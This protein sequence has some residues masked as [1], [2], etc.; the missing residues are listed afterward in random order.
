MRKTK[1]L[2][3]H[4][5]CKVSVLNGVSYLEI[6]I[7]TMRQVG[8]TLFLGTAEQALDLALLAAQDAAERISWTFRQALPEA[9]EVSTQCPTEHCWSPC[10]Q[11][12]P[13]NFF[14]GSPIE[15]RAAWQVRIRWDWETPD[16]HP[17]RIA[18]RAL[19]EEMRAK[20]IISSLTNNNNTTVTFGSSWQAKT[21]KGSTQWNPWKDQLKKL[22]IPAQRRSNNAHHS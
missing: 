17:A 2:S 10:L 20:M 21:F 9:I 7:F 15:A 18:L 8:Q 13:G 14:G 1:K 19:T 3:S 22:D 6:T 16:D 12:Q 5:R 4:D 11:V